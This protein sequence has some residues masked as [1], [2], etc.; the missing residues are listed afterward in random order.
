MRR[1]R[2][3]L[4]EQLRGAIR[5]RAVDH[6]AVPGDPADICGA[7]EDVGLR[8]QVEHVL[9]G[10]RHLRE[11]AARRV[12]D[13]LRLTRRARGVED[14]QRVLGL[15]GL[16]HVLRL[17][18]L[19]GVVPPQV[20]AVHPLDV[21]VAT[22]D[23]QHARHGARTVGECGIH[24]GFQGEDLALAP[25]AVGGD[26]QLGFGVV[27]AAAQ[28]LGAEAAEHHRVHRAE[29]G[30]GEHGDDRLRHNRHVDRD[31]V[32]LADAERRDRIGGALDLGGQLRV[33]EAD[34]VA[35]LALPVDGDPVADAGLHVPVEAV[36]GDVELAVGEPLREGCVAPVEH[37][38][39]GLVPVHVLPGA[40]GPEGEAVG[41]GIRVE[42]RAGHRVGREIGARWK[43]AV[44]MEQAV[45][46]IG[47]HADP[48]RSRG[49]ARMPRTVEQVTVRS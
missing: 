17:G 20:P 43:V 41:L 35:V 6:V 11:V 39:E 33:G 10:E 21:V 27:D 37:L 36:V 1:V 18:R 19:D 48:R 23:D 44:L 8:V 25:A 45:N 31:P 47:R 2:R 24:G 15:E 3:S 14:E 12:Q 46:R 28:A 9:V 32:A 30:D 42:A 4:I 40:V 49:A 7:P 26:D 22:L 34:G 16:S 38:G 13:A 29:P 5:Q